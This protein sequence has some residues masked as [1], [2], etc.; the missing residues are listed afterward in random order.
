MLVRGHSRHKLMSEKS[1]LVLL[2]ILLHDILPEDCFKKFVHASVKYTKSLLKLLI[3][4]LLMMNSTWYI[5]SIQNH[6]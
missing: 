4:Y 5:A 1:K 3:V 2:S 6:K